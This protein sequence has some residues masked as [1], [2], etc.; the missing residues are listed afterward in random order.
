MK[1]S[2]LRLLPGSLLALLVSASLSLAG[3]VIKLKTGEKLE[4]VI[5]RESATEVVI[6]VNVTGS[7]VEEKKIP[8]TE[9]AEV[10]K[11][12]PDQFEAADL[13][14]LSPSEDMMTDATYQS[15]LTEKLEPFL[16]KYPVSRYKAD[17]EAIIATYK[18]EMEKAKSGAKKLEGV[19]ILPEE[20]AWNNY[21][22]EARLRRVE[23]EKLIK[24][25]KLQDAYRIM[26]DLEINKPASVETV[27]A[28]EL[29]KAAIPDLERTLDRL[30]I[31]HPIKIKNRLEGAKALSPEERKRFDEA[32]K[33]E[34][35]DLKLLLDEDRKQ[36]MGITSFS[37]YDLKS[38]TDAKAALVKEA[39]RLAKID[40][41]GQKA[42]ATAFQ[43]GLKNF[44]E[45]SYLSAQR[46]FEDASKVFSKD[47]FIKERID[48]SKKAAAEASRANAEATAARPN[49]ALATTTPSGKPGDPPAPKAKEPAKTEGG[50]PVKKTAEPA[51]NQDEEET[52]A[53]VEE[54][55]N[56][57]MIL[58]A[59]AVVLLL[60]LV[61]VKSLAKKKASADD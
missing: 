48:L 53:V 37:E 26:A 28:I 42:A 20:L 51:A 21:N 35:A 52:E 54:S 15:I 40:L 33:K 50:A 45:K 11:A 57:P 5:L 56:L 47:N 27:R 1:S 18:E 29:F 55:S 19:W 24:A 10:I 3:D 58:I 34:E 31:E 8:L 59:G 12:T 6:K 49:P 60:T 46:N 44:H 38:L 25:G 39:A 4:G 61:V 23:M 13:A 2:S 43:S 14:K 16:K 22:F 32:I 30:I 41:E 9:I 7:I 17:I 36:K